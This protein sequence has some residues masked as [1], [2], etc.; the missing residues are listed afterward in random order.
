MEFHKAHNS[1]STVLKSSLIASLFLTM[2]A[3]SSAPK[4][5]PD[6]SLPDKEPP[7][8]NINVVKND[9]RNGLHSMKD[10]SATAFVFYSKP[11][12]YLIRGQKQ[13]PEGQALLEVRERQEERTAMLQ[14]ALVESCDECANFVVKSPIEVLTEPTMLSL[15]DKAA[16][17][18]EPTPL[19]WETLAKESSSSDLLFV[20]LGKDEIDQSRV[21]AEQKDV[22]KSTTDAIVNLKV[23]LYDIRKAKSLVVLNAD[24]IEGESLLY[25]RVSDLS[26][27]PGS[28]LKRIKNSIVFGPS[29]ELM[30]PKLDDVY[31]Y[32]HALGH[33]LILR[34]TISRVI[35]NLSP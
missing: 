2:A 13:M 11:D 32:P 10:R 6:L 17:G 27:S 22:I 18:I 31:P 25:A 30:D 23:I 35:E 7:R 16:L 19:D 26:S 24:G 15:F 29:E 4:E 8:F 34:K 5:A 21:I 33:S 28:L 1:I 9:L 20:I 14:E 12:A 3:C